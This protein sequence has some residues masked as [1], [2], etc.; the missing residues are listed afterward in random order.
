[1]QFVN[2][3]GTTATTQSGTIAA[4][5]S[6]TFFPLGDPPSGFTGNPV[7]TAFNGSVVISSNQPVAAITN[8]LRSDFA[9][10]GSYNGFSSGDTNVTLPIIMKNNSGFN[11]YFNVQNLGS[12]DATVNIAYTPGLSGSAASEPAATIKAG[13]A[14]TYTQAD[15]TALGTTFIGIAKVTSTQPVAVTVNQD[16]GA[17]F[18]TYDGIAASKAATTSLQ[19]LVMANNSGFFTGI[20]VTN[21]GGAATDVTITYSANTATG[22][23]ACAGTPPVKTFPDVAANAGV[24]SL[25]IGDVSLGGD[26]YFAT[27]QYIGSAIVT[28][29]QNIVAVTNQLGASFSSAYEG[30]N[31]ADAT[32]SVKLPLLMSNNG[33]YFT[34]VQIQN[35]AASGTPAVAVSITF[36]PN[37]ATG[38]SACATPTAVTGTVAGGASFTKL[39]LAG[40]DQGDP[41]FNG[42]TYVGSA[43]VSGPAG[44]KLLAIVNELSLAGGGDTLL[45]YSGFN[46]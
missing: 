27:C 8:I 34:G 31:P 3:D 6:V 12:D 1:V 32:A 45:T 29:D 2:Q 22:G 25:Q 10:G 20:G 24:F 16:G 26:P 35:A 19:P 41:Q 15:N 5:Q 43:T 23:T 38:S 30:F 17:L 33:G 36:G 21:V 44:S 9:A 42:C 13:A 11:T 40:G 37:T 46:Q 28:A 14:K 39:Q 18:L 7:P 4:N